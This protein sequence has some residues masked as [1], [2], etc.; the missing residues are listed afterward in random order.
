MFDIQKY[1]ENGTVQQTK[2]ASDIKYRD[3]NSEDLS[4]I[5]NNPIIKASFFGEGYKNKLPE[6]Q[7]TKQYL[8][9]LACAA[10]ADCFNAEYLYHLDEVAEYVNR[11][12]EKM[13]HSF[14]IG[15]AIVAAAAAVLLIIISILN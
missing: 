8:D 14:I 10:I 7:W 6:E 12:K 3:I 13:N 4:A 15:A 2:I 9:E 1:I 5:V 11:K